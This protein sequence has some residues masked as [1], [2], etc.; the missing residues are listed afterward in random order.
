MSNMKNWK[1]S[2]FK[3]YL[4]QA[5]SL[6]SSNA[7]QYSIIWWITINTKSSLSLTFAT[8]AGILPQALLG[9]FVG[10][11]VDRHSRKN[12]NYTRYISGTS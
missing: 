1:T 6:I 12:Y 9:T 7:I 3:L 11:I 2:F 5:F 10:V 4:G 8:I